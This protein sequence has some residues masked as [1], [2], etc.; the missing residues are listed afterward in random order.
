VSRRLD[1]YLGIEFE[2]RSLDDVDD[3]MADGL[4]DVLD[5]FWR[6]LSDD[7]R[8]FLNRRVISSG[9]MY[10]VRLPVDGFFITPE[11]ERPLAPRPSKDPIVVTDWMCVPPDGLDLPKGSGS[12][13]S[14]R[15]PT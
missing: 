1:A 3:P 8:A 12:A 7:E 11:P 9:P 10:G 13:T 14:R 4:R 15:G 6:A 5:L 2:M